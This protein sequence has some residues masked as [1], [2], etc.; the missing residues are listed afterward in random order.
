MMA[1]ILLLVAMGLV[2]L[3]AS[4]GWIWVVLIPA[5]LWAP[6]WGWA[7]WL[8][9]DGTTNRLHLGID[10]TWIALVCAWLA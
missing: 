7:R 10:A 9:R 2:G 3:G 5:L 6:G 1:L 4:T 8:S